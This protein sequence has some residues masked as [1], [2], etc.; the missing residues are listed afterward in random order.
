MNQNLMMKKL[1]FVA[2]LA[3]TGF[4]FAAHAQP[5]TASPEAVRKAGERMS[6]GDVAGAI[7]ILDKAI[8]KKKDLF[9]IYRMR[10]SL[11]MMTRDVNGAIDDL[12]RAL[13]AKPDDAETY[14][15]RA[16][17]LMFVRKNE[18]ALK[19]YDSAI[20]HGL[21]TEKVFTGRGQ[22]KRDM[23]EFD[24]AVVDFQAA[25]ALRPLYASAYLGLA[26]TFELQG[27]TDAAKATLE[28]FVNQYEDYK[29]GKL[30]KAKGEQIGEIITIE[31][32]GTEKNNSQVFM[33]GV[34]RRIEVKENST[35]EDL[36][37]QTEQMEQ[38]M[39]AAA[40]YLNLASSYRRSSDPDKALAT[41]EK[42]LAMNPSDPAATAT[43]GAIR[44]DKGDVTGALGDLN[45]AIRQMP[46]NYTLLAD[47]GIALLMQGKDA[48]AE[49]DFELFFQKFPKARETLI[50]RIAVAKEKRAAIS[51]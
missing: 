44:L 25:I 24:A 12:T 27:K 50:K 36:Q 26:H 9:E 34:Q 40:V 43:R 10:S 16:N 22:I 47:R 13:E 11:R 35:P 41:I 32:E 37:R 49:K 6:Q 29:N 8:E 18:L 31:R 19:D 45:Y 38:R 4:V 23:G 17:L 3:L 30:P 1:F 14:A 46:G 42:S 21:K 15:N 20:A 2:C 28:S 48:E 7:A 5:Q 51:Q 33:Q 39:N